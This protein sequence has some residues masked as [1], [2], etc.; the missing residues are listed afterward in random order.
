MRNGRSGSATSPGPCS[1]NTPGRSE[2]FEPPRACSARKKATQMSHPPPAEFAGEMFVEE[3][4]APPVTR[5][6][7]FLRSVDRGV[8]RATEFAASAL[9]VA[10]VVLLGI[11]TGARYLFSHPYPWSDELATLI[12]IWLAVLGAVVALRRTEHMRLT[13]FIR[14][15]SPRNR[16]WL[17]SVAMMLVA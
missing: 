6:G 10:E 2:P 13:A 8:S 5:A 14:G 11:S 15:M 12:F 16:A 9:V 17:D 3:E 7:Q 1:R 4:G